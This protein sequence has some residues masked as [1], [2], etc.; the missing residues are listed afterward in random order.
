MT[1][2]AFRVSPDNI[3]ADKI[4]PKPKGLH[5]QPADRANIIHTVITP[6]ASR[7]AMRNR[8]DYYVTRH[9]ANDSQEVI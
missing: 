2:D 4:G 9:V 3:E 7:L 1:R 8:R 5:K 6:M